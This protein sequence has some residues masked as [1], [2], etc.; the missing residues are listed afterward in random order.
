MSTWEERMAAKA[1]AR[2]RQ[3]EAAQREINARDA[4]HAVFLS[5]ERTR[6]ESNAVENARLIAAGPPDG[7]HDCWEFSEWDKFG[8][9]GKWHHRVPDGWYEHYRSGT[10]YV[11]THSCHSEPYEVYLIALAAP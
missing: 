9:P 2:R 5:H 1:A 10:P 4:A 6:R 7:C 11:C 8:G 3:R